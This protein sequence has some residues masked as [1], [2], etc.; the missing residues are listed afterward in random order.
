VGGGQPK[1]RRGISF[2]IKRVL[3]SGL[4]SPRKEERDVHEEMP[5]F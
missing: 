5:R 4:K 1:R 2:E 3:A